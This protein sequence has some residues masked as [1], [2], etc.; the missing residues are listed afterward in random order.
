MEKLL[1]YLN[2]LDAASKEAFALRCSTS[3]AYLR[4]AISIN[5][6]LGEGLCIAIERESG[7]VVRCE[8]LRADVDWAFLRGTSVEE[9]AA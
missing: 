2:G 1:E 4:K 6:R 5:Q 9:K 7:G 3:L 8:Y